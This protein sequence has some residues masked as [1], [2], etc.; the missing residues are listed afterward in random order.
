QNVE[1]DSD[2]SVMGV[3]NVVSSVM[4]SV[5]VSGQVVSVTSVD[6]TW[7]S[8]KILSKSDA[9]T[10]GSKDFQSRDDRSL[11]GQRTAS[12]AQF[13]SSNVESVV[14]S[15]VIDAFRKDTFLPSSGIVDTPFGHSHFV[16]DPNVSTPSV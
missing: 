12:G 1:S 10:R 11:S 14:P 4:P 8:N 3:Q 16:R 7:G 13:Q 5:A 2:L 9:R 6:P 15:H